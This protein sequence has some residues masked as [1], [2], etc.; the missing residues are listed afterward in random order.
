ME[1]PTPEK[2][3][4]MYMK[5]NAEEK[6]VIPFFGHAFNNEYLFNSFYSSLAFLYQQN[7]INEKRSLRAF[8]SE[9]M[10]TSMKGVSFGKK[11]SYQ[12]KKL[13]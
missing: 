6:K 2:K 11:R 10:N 5:K 3:H 4:K 13:S 1:N 8:S 12:S 7:L 9:L